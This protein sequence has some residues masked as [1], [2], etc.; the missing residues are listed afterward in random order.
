M[1][2]EDAPAV[3]AYCFSSISLSRAL[4][5][6]KC[7]LLCY[8]SFLALFWRSI[9]NLCFYSTLSESW[10][11]QR[12]RFVLVRTSKIF[13]QMILTFPLPSISLSIG[14]TNLCE[15]QVGNSDWRWELFAFCW[16]IW[17]IC[18]DWTCWSVS[19]SWGNLYFLSQNYKKWKI[20]R[21]NLLSDKYL[22]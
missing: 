19:Y 14:Y 13:W 17:E 10:I 5:L 16:T 9:R 11:L 3:L 7:G 20:S 15:V 21:S 2:K 6:D 4:C 18:P 8:S 12:F 22:K 1:G